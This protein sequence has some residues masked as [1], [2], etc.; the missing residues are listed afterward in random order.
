MAQIF[1]TPAEIAEEY[2]TTLKT[3]KPE[4]NT[5]QTDSDWWI[6]AQVIG[7]VGSGIYAD[8]QLLSDD[9]FPQ[10]A[11]PEAIEK[12][13]ITYFGTGFTPA[14]PAAGLALVTGASGSIIPVGTEFLYSPN[15]N[16]YQATDEL[17]L[18]SATGGLIPVESVQTGQDQNLLSGAV[19][20]LSSPPPG[21]DSSASASGNISDGRNQE[22][23]EEA[24]TRVLERIRTPL[25]GGK[26]SDYKQ[27]AREAD[28]AVVDAN[29]LRFPFGFGTVGVVIKAGTTD[30]DEALDN[31]QPVI[32]TPSSGLIEE[33]QAYIETKKP[34]TDCVT[35]MAPVEVPIDVTV[36]VRYT[37]GDNSTILS[38]QT[39]TNSELVQREVQ[40]ALYKTPAGGRVL[41]ASGYVVAS[42]IEEVID[43]NLSASPYAVGELVELLTDRR[44]DDL[45]ATGANRSLLGNEIA[46]PGIITI[47]EQ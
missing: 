1:K 3:L 24:A 45:S 35:V 16:T 2:L 34:V 15:G 25:A 20:T 4:V 19:L 14:Q 40:R 39:L 26:V 9:P 33:V 17:D 23:P 10:S 13:L 38:G 32:F 7:G 36:R 6:R 41:G 22:T 37:S 43:L 11:R 5:N 21:I 31:G 44:V 27:F 8:Q 29:V 18:G 12:H 47:V 46:I 30:V 42:E 28:P